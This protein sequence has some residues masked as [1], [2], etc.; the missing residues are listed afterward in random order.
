MTTGATTLLGLALPVQ[1]ELDG[2]WGDTVNNSLTNLLDTAIAGTTTIST[3]ADITLT[4]TQLASNQAR[5]AIILWTATGSTTRNIT[6]PARSKSYLVINAT[7]GSQ[8]IV[9]RGAGPTTGVA[10]PAGARYVVA[11]NGSD[12]VYVSG[13]TPGSNTQLL[14]N[15]SGVPGASSNLTFD[16]SNLQI[17]NQGDLRLGDADNSNYVAIQSPA[18]VSVNWTITL[19]S[20]DGTSGQLLTTNGSG[21]LSFTNTLTTPTI[22]GGYT[23]QY[24]STSTSGSVTISLANGSVQLFTITGTTTF[25]FP[26][27]TNGV[28]FMLFIRQDA[29]GSR[30]VNWPGTVYW[31]S[32]TTP[33]LTTTASRMDKF[34]F[35]AANGTWTG[36]VAGQNYA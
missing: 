23:E 17:G 29:T 19:P 26:S 10:V 8:S 30:A 3:D 24:Y 33:T 22:N 32:G 15:N 28:S 18:T 5:Q 34:V 7:G 21:A 1:G 14:Y 12:F 13:S 25:T 31:P 9:I 36:S 27:A 2:T 20:A 6:A 11:W 16:G 35:T 4:D